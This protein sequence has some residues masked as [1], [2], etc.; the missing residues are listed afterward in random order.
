MAGVLLSI[1]GFRGSWRMSNISS[2]WLGSLVL[3]IDTF[4]PGPQHLPYLLIW[5]QSDNSGVLPIIHA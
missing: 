3:H 2:V 4:F 1:F 5:K